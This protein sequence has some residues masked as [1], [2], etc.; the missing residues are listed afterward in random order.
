MVSIGL[1]RY[2]DSLATCVSKQLIFLESAQL[3]LSIF[4]AGGLFVLDIQLLAPECSHPVFSLYPVKWFAVMAI[5]PFVYGTLQCVLVVRLRLAKLSQ[6]GSDVQIGC[7]IA[8]AAGLIA[9]SLVG[10]FASLPQGVAIGAGVAVCGSALAHLCLSKI[11]ATC[12]WVL[13]DTEWEFQSTRNVVVVK[14]HSGRNLRPSDKNGLADPFVEVRFGDVTK[15]GK[16]V[17][18]S[19]EPTWSDETFQFFCAEVSSEDVVTVDV[20][21]WD[22]VS[23]NDHMGQAIVACGDM[24]RSMKWHTLLPTPDCHDPQGEVQITATL[25]TGASEA[26]SVDK[27]AQIARVLM[28]LVKLMIFLALAFPFTSMSLQTDAPTQSILQDC[29]SALGLFTVFIALPYTVICAG[30]HHYRPQNSVRQALLPWL[31]NKQAATEEE[32]SDAISYN[33]TFSVFILVS[34]LIVMAI[35]IVT[36]YQRS[37]G[38]AALLA[39][40]LFTGGMIDLKLLRHMVQSSTTTQQESELNLVDKWRTTFA[41]PR[42]LHLN[43]Y[44]QRLE[45]K[46]MNVF[47]LYLLVGYMNIGKN[48]MSVWDCSPPN[49]RG[50]TFLDANP[51]WECDWEFTPT[52]EFGGRAYWLLSLVAQYFFAPLYVVGIPMFVAYMMVRGVNDP[53]AANITGSLTEKVRGLSP[54]V[55]SSPCCE[56]L[57]KRCCWCV[58]YEPQWYAWELCIVARKVIMVLITMFNT[59][60]PTQGC[61]L[62]SLVLIAFGFSHSYARPFDFDSLDASEFLSICSSLIIIIA[63]LGYATRDGDAFVD[64]TG[65]K[66]DP[67]VQTLNACVWAVLLLNIGLNLVLQVCLIWAALKRAR[68]ARQDD[69]LLDRSFQEAFQFEDDNEEEEEEVLSQNRYKELFST[70]YSTWLTTWTDD[71]NADP[72]VV[73]GVPWQDLGPKQRAAADTLKLTQELWND[74]A[75]VEVGAFTRPWEQLSA[76]EQAALSTLGVHYS[77]SVWLLNGIRD[78]CVGDGTRRIMP[79]DSLIEDSGFNQVAYD[80]KFDRIWSRDVLYRIAVWIDSASPSELALLNRSLAEISSADWEHHWA[81]TDVLDSKI[82]VSLGAIGTTLGFVTSMWIEGGSWWTTQASIQHGVATPLR[83]T[84]RMAFDNDLESAWDVKCCV[85]DDARPS[86]IF[87]LDVAEP[88]KAYT[89]VTV[90]NKCP[91]SW[92]L[93]ATDEG[94]DWVVADSQ[95]GQA[96]PDSDFATYELNV[97]SL[98]KKQWRW[99]F[100]Q[101]AQLISRRDDDASTIRLYE[102]QLVPKQKTEPETHFHLPREPTAVLVWIATLTAIATAIGAALHRSEKAPF[103]SLVQGSVPRWVAIPT[104]AEPEPELESE[105]E[106]DPTHEPASEP[107]PEP[108]PTH[109]PAPEPEPEPEP[110]QEGGTASTCAKQLDAL[111]EVEEEKEHW[112]AAVGERIVWA[113]SDDYLLA[114]SVGQVV[115]VDGGGMRRVRFTGDR[116]LEFTTDELLDKAQP[117]EEYHYRTLICQCCLPCLLATGMLRACSK[118]C[119][120]SRVGRWTK[121]TCHTLASLLVATFGFVTY[122]GRRSIHLPVPE[123]ATA[124]SA[125]PFRMGC[126]A[127]GLKCQRKERLR[128]YCCARWSFCWFFGLLHL[129]GVLCLGLIRV[130]VVYPTERC[131]NHNA[132]A[133]ACDQCQSSAGCEDCLEHR[134][135]AGATSAQWEEPSCQWGGGVCELFTTG[136]FDAPCTEEY[137]NYDDDP[138]SDGVAYFSCDSPSN[139]GDSS[140][141]CEWEHRVWQ[142]AEDSSIGVY[143]YS[144]E[145]CGWRRGDTPEGDEPNDRGYSV[146]AWAQQVISLYIVSLP[147]PEFA[148][149]ERGR[150]NFTE[151]WYWFILMWHGGVVWLAWIIGNPRVRR[152]FF[153]CCCMCYGAPCYWLMH[154]VN[155]PPDIRAGLHERGLESLLIGLSGYVWA[156]GASIF[157]ILFI[158]YPKAIEDGDVDPD[159]RGSWDD[160]RPIASCLWLPCWFAWTGFIISWV[161]C[162]CGYRARPLC[163]ELCRKRRGEQASDAVRPADPVPVG[164][165]CMKIKSGALGLFTAKRSPATMNGGASGDASHAREN[166]FG[167]SE[168]YDNPLSLAT[169]DGPAED[170][171]EDDE[172]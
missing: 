167:E 23:A 63:G 58:Q 20:I 33:H 120:S 39:I 51:S 11:E 15:K 7:A 50:Q 153:R 49:E 97:P 98:T 164:T 62:G 138:P 14:V 168:Q 68:R 6:S 88:V 60:N 102:V 84:A 132:L 92:T 57:S 100:T 119:P 117:L 83:G 156:A 151:E 142:H 94:E 106:P 17:H 85:D 105:P 66:A 43:E 149:W 53:N 81:W 56:L 69:H 162:C 38:G 52:Y 8:K 104:K 76:E 121:R 158:A 10:I 90:G 133:V 139:P 163:Y 12:S 89:F 59:Q 124:Y 16:V 113:K 160:Y 36:V 91:A 107:E 169:K 86:I 54:N 78:F 136:A 29:M 95:E 65:A 128:R 73:V 145:M 87:T 144:G 41:M 80:D 28:L 71:A 18:E 74:S 147:W 4:C 172:G 141:E 13:T 134:L 99:T 77:E 27:P 22:R 170:H 116:E 61:F 125:P 155:A 137:T 48:V 46:K 42:T 112:F 150:K 24:E 135:S 152:P 161:L 70:K 5:P 130:F 37:P 9:A 143:T 44:R 165:K 82:I 140:C 40:A 64:Q 32:Q 19:L 45:Q 31:G 108:E 2:C 96:C 171:S 47:M 159:M 72:V 111:A 126:V 67:V 75:Q 166:E 35:V 115:H 55:F 122:D 30:L 26:M 109:E 114:G 127:P 146:V 93:E 79:G 25:Q 101:A 123:L 3:R 118:C 21:D 129:C 131:R 148:R 110:E 103:S 154:C 1:R 157:A 34:G